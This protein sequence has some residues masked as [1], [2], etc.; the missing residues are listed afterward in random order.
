MLVRRYHPDYLMVQPMGCD[1]V[2]HLE[3]GE[4]DDYMRQASKTDRLLAEMEPGWLARGYHVLVTSDHG[5]DRRGQQGGTRPEVTT[6]PLYHLGCAHGRAYDE[7]ASQLSIAP[8]FLTLMHLKPG[9]T[10]TAPIL[11]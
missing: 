6:V 10:M 4:S 11:V 8:T 1:E 5:M 9:E 3:G 7:E 2:G